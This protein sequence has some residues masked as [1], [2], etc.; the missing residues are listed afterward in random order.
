MATESTP[1]FR[2]LGPYETRGELG[3]GGMAIV[4]QGLQPSLNRPVAIKVLPEQFAAQPELLARFEREGTIIAQ[5]NHPNIV[6]V[7]DRGRQG[8]T[9]Y[10]VMEYLE[11]RNLNQTV[12][13]GGPIPVERAIPILVAVCGA[14]TRRTTWGS[15]TGI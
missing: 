12:R 3:R 8:N 15:C 2:T 9:L 10:I 4:Y 11:G 1:T 14:W 13:K 5:L 7:I 6:Q